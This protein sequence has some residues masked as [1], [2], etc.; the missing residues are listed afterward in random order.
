[1]GNSKAGIMNNK[2]VTLTIEEY[3]NVMEKQSG[4]NSQIV[5]KSL[6]KYLKSNKK[7]QALAA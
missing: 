3:F 5:A 1:M 4:T 7:R 2:Y 6:V